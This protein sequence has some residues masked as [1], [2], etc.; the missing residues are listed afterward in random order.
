[1]RPLTKKRRHT[2]VTYVFYS[3]DTIVGRKAL[4]ATRFSNAT[5]FSHGKKFRFKKK[6]K[7]FSIQKKKNESQ[8][9]LFFTPFSFCF[10]SQTLGHEDK[11]KKQSP[12]WPQNFVT[13]FNYKTRLC[14]AF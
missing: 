6:K 11:K 13:H 4:F 8:G 9:C 2:G 10:S 12:L 1:M 7:A 3:T 14:K 5:R